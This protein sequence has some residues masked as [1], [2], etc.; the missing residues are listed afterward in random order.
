MKCFQVSIEYSDASPVAL[1]SASNTPKFD[2]DDAF[3]FFFKPSPA[4]GN[5]SEEL[6]NAIPW[7]D[8]NCDN[9][10]NST[11]ITNTFDETS[12][13][14]TSLHDEISELSLSQKQTDKI[15]ELC[16]K[17]I[18]RVQLLNTALIDHSNVMDVSQV[19]IS[20]YL[21]FSQ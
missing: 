4:D 15:F 10:T 13:F 14:L 19:R 11:K 3:K 5:K 17:V 9:V 16:Y 1:N 21:E 7:I 8:Y 12:A 18:D 6:T 2:P 20:Y